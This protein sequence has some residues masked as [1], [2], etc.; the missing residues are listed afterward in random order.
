MLSSQLLRTRVRLFPL[1]VLAALALSPTMPASAGSLQVDPVKLEI[2]KQ[3]KI[4]AVSVKNLADTPV[5]IRGYAMSWTQV[6]GEDIAEKISSVIVSPPV[7]T[8]A[9]G[10]SQLVRVGMRPSAAK[11]GTYRMIVEEVPVANVEG[12]IQVVLRLNMPLFVNEKQGKVEE[13]VWKSWQL[14]NKAWVLEAR[15]PG[16]NYVPVE[17]KDVA[18]K[19]GLKFDGSMHGTVLPKG[20]RRWTLGETPTIVDPARFAQISGARDQD[21]QLQL[22][23]KP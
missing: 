7:F 1:W 6:N 14:P 10:A 12:G 8:I 20:S 9:P 2:S 17:A 4:T 5:T 16:K 15:N 11:S 3:R 19:T 23:S 21:A 18:E 13:L 22:A